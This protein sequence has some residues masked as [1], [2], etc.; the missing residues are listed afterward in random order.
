MTTIDTSFVPS[1]VVGLVI[2]TFG[3]FIV[4]LIKALDKNT[5]TN[6]EFGKQII[7]LSAK[8]DHFGNTLKS[9]DVQTNAEIEALKDRCI[10]AEIEIKSLRESRHEYGTSIQRTEFK[11]EALQREINLKLEAMF[12]RAQTQ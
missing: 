4:R 11:I 2:T 6:V 3:F 10:K 1:L 9:L 7:V 5:E 8:I 12:N